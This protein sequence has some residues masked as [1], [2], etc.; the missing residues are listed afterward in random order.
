MNRNI[1]PV[2]KNLLYINI[3][4]FLATWLLPG[5][6]AR[7]NISLDLF[8]VLGMH[9]FASSKFN[10]VQIVTYMFMHAPFP[11][12]T[13][14]FFNMFA[15][16]MF[17][18]ILEYVWGSRKFLIYYL[19]T[20]IGAGLVQQLFWYVDLG[21]MFS[22]MNTAISSGSTEVL[23]PFMDKLTRFYRF[24]GDIS[25]IT[26]A[27]ILMMKNEIQNALLTVGASGSIFGILLAFG[28][29]FPEEKLFLLFIPIPIKARYFV[30][31]YA[32]LELFMG[33]AN[34][35]G[36][37]VAHFAHLGGMLFGIVLILMW[38]KKGRLYDRQ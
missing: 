7:W 10:P 8:D 25:M 35:S 29:L 38:R 5:I 36:D 13:H 16:Y 23:I 37:S 12:I 18:P 15:L 14:I 11:N 33:V 34:F 21:G 26:S 24:S 6:L 32:V 1:P 9:Y 27:D 4:M 22:A 3:I 28:W 20:G 30:V 19:V 2:V 31:G 17:G